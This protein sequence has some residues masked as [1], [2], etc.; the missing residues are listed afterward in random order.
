M[1]LLLVAASILALSAC[2]SSDV[3]EEYAG[4]KGDQLLLQTGNYSSLVKRYQDQLKENPSPSLRYK[5]ANALYLSG[6]PEAAQ[7]QL[8]LIPYDA[9]EDSE[10]EM[11]RANVLYDLDR[12][13]AAEQ[14]VNAALRIYDNNA[15]AYNLKGLLLAQRGELNKAKQAFD[16]ARL[17]GFDDDIVK[18]NLAM[19]A[20]LKGDFDW[21]ADILLPL[22]KNGRSDSIVEANLLLALAKSGRSREFSQLLASEGSRETINERYTSI[23]NVEAL[24]RFSQNSAQNNASTRSSSEDS[25]KAPASVKVPLTTQAPATESINK[26]DSILAANKQRNKPKRVLADSAPIQNIEAVAKAKDETKN[27]AI[28]IAMNASSKTTRSA[29]SASSTI[30]VPVT[31]TTVTKTSKAAIVPTTKPIISPPAKE[32]LGPLE[33]A[34]QRVAAANKAKAEKAQQEKIHSLAKKEAKQAPPNIKKPKKKRTRYL[35]TDINYLKTNGVNE[36]TATSDFEL[37]KIRTQYLEK[38]K[39]WVFDIE[40]AKNFT[41]KRKRYLKNGPAKAIELG[42]HESFVRIVL[43]MHEKTQQKPDIKVEGNTLTIRWDS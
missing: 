40:G 24:G 14:H 31:N 19:V 12:L 28:P 27:N 3:L 4:E 25:N 16:R 39:K 36:Y 35:V 11:L 41:T 7:F 15:E 17:H 20:I 22:V 21:A 30:S 1:K 43:E 32:K 42:E 6:D 9:I 38:R 29:V 2:S 5:L 33:L 10:L 8:A 13:N 23:N 37:G 18:N 34:R 26:I